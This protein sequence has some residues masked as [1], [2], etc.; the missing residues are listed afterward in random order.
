MSTIAETPQPVPHYYALRTSTTAAKVI[1]WMVAVPHAL[2]ALLN[3]LVALHQ[4]VQ[5]GRPSYDP[6]IVLYALIFVGWSG[7]WS[8]LALAGISQIDQLRAEC[9]RRQV[10]D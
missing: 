9:C 8:W 5:M 2:L 7:F 1:L 10:N 3:V 6:F 4:I